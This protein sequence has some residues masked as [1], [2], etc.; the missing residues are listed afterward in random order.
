MGVNKTRNNKPV[1]RV[2]HLGSGGVEI[3]SD[4]D[5][6]I[7]SNE[8]VGGRRLM[9]VAIVVVDAP[10]TNDHRIAIACHRG[11]NSHWASFS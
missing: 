3:R 6:F 9:D 10:A 7:S 1:S 8:D 11:A 2:Q 4:C 5:D